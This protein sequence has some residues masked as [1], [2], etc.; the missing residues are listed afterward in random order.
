MIKLYNLMFIIYVILY[1]KILIKFYFNFPS[2]CSVS[3]LPIHVTRFGAYTNKYFIKFYHLKLFNLDRE[4][5]ISF[6]AASSHFF[7]RSVE[8]ARYSESNLQDK[9]RVSTSAF[10][11]GYGDGGGGPTQDQVERANRLKD[12]DG[13][14]K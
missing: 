12:V 8:Q 2:C 10:L 7:L 11:F 6:S 3:I 13:C 14:P 4:N 1:W 9:G 5:H